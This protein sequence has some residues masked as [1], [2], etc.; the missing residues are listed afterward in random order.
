MRGLVMSGGGSKCAAFLGEIKAAVEEG[1]EFDLYSGTSGGGLISAELSME[2]TLAAGLARAVKTWGS[3][4]GDKDIYKN[5]FFGPVQGLLQKGDKCSKYNSAPLWDLIERLFDPSKV[6]KKLRIGAVGFNGG[7]RVWDESSPPDEL[8]MAVKATS[9]FP[10]EFRPI[11]WGGDLW[12]DAG[13]TEVVPLQAAID[14][15]CTE[16]YVM[17]ASPPGLQPMKNVPKTAV[18]GQV[19]RFLDLM[20]VEIKRDD[21]RITPPDGVVIHHIQPSE[22][23]HDDSLNFSPKL[24]EATIRKGYELAKSV[25]GSS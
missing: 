10:L 2:R 15:G 1:L 20:S 16:I 4:K 25:L 11:K 9:A 18:F 8:M 7:Y 17:H 14:A 12:T 22:P 23:F 21:V 24:M 3:V 13:I 19:K 5:W 6:V